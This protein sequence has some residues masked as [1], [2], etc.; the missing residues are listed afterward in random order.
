MRVRPPGGAEF[1]VEFEQLLTDTSPLVGQELDVVFD[2]ADHSKI[3]IDTRVD[4]PNVAY[5]KAVESGD[6]AAE[7]AAMARM[8]PDH[9]RGPDAE[10]ALA[11]RLAAPTPT[12]DPADIGARI[13]QAQ[14]LNSL[15]A[16]GIVAPG[17]VNALHPAG[18][19]ARG[20]GQPTQVDVTISP[21]G[22]AAFA[23]S[24]TQTFLPSQL[25]GLTAGT[26]VQVRYDAANPSVA[27]LVKW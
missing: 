4:A 11:A 13:A 15:R 6:T 24:F 23:T 8:M 1:D 22:A 7:A 14:A 18:P 27:M 12:I 19:I 2:A 16:T 5:E 10:A 3:L 21:P 25:L 17:V 9:Y 26:A 20:A